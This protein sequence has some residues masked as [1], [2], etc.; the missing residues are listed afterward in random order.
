MQPEPF[1]IFWIKR[2]FVSLLSRPLV[3][4]YKADDL[5]QP[6]IWEAKEYFMAAVA[7]LC[8]QRMV[9]LWNRIAFLRAWIIPESAPCTHIC[10]LPEGQNFIVQLIKRH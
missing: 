6:H 9:R 1:I 10:L 3:K 7:C 2:K 4:V 5:R 8:R